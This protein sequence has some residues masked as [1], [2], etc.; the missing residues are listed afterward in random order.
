MTKQLER[1]VKIIRGHLAFG[2]LDAAQRISDS[3][4]RAAPSDAAR[5]KVIAALGM[6]S[7][8]TIRS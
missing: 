6:I 3:L 5:K 8:L 4:I 1:E 7:E 2:N